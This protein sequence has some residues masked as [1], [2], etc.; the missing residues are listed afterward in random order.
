MSTSVE[1]RDDAGSCRCW[2]AVIRIEH[3]LSLQEDTCN[4]QEFVGDATE[5]AAMGMT[6]LAQS[7]VATTAL[8]VML[9]G[10]PRPMKDHV[11]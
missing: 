2:S 11:A 10:C 8:G 4:L 1:Q 9:D 7:G 5:G 6:S 3:R